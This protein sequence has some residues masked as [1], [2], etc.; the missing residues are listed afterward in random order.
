MAKKTLSVFLSLT[1]AALPLARP[2]AA[3]GNPAAQ[4]SS[5]P[6]DVIIAYYDDPDDFDVEDILELGGTL[7]YV[8][9]LV[10]AIAATVPESA[11]VE[12]TENFLVQRVDLDLQVHA[13]DAELDN[14][15]GVKRIGSGLVH[16][17]ANLGLGVKVAVLDSGID[18]IH[19][20]LNANFAGGHD[21]VNNDADPMD[22]EGHGTHV[23]GSIAAE[24][25]NAGLVGVA[26][27]AS[28]YVLKVL[29]QF[30]N[31][32]YSDI[33]AAL[34]WAVDN[35]M[36][37]TNNSY[38]SLGDPGLTVKQA[39]DNAEAAGLLNVAA[40]DNAGNC[41]GTGDSVNFPA[42]Y[43][44]VIAVAAT[45]STDG[46]PCFSSTGP[47]VEIAAPGVDINSTLLGGG[48]GL[49]SGTSMATPHVAGTGALVIA[50][51]ITDQNLNGRINDEVR[52]RM[53]Q[54]AEDLGLPAEWVGNGLVDADAA[55][56]SAPPPGE[57]A[58]LTVT[59]G[60]DQK[61]ETTLLQEGKVYV[62]QASDDDWWET[63]DAFFTS[64]QFSDAAVPAGATITS[65][66]IQVEHW[67]EK[68]FKGSVRW[69]AGTGW[70]ASPQVW[71]TNDSVPL[72]KGES[73]E[74]QDSGDVTAA[75]NTPA[76]INALELL[77]VNNGTNGKKTLVDYISV[78]VSWTTAPT[79]Q[80]PVADP[81]SATTAEDTPKAI[82]LTGS[83]LDGDPLT[84]TVLSQ[85]ANGTLS[86][87]APNLTYSPNADFNGS[88]SFTFKVNDGTV[89]S[90]PATVS[91][92][93]TAVN[94]APVAQDQQVSTKQGEPV[95]ITLAASDA[96]G[97]PLTYAVATAPTNGLLSGTPPNLTY[98]PNAGFSGTDSF[99]F[100]ANDGVLDSNLGTVTMTVAPNNP[101]TADP[102]SVTTAEDTPKAITLT[103]SDLDSDPLTFTV[104]SQPA[105]GTLSGTAPNLT[106]APKADFNGSDSFTF[107]VNDGLADS[108]PATVS[109]TVTAVNDA[110]TADD[111][112]V[113]TDQDTPVAVTLTAS[114]A[115]GDPLTFT[116]LTLP[117]NGTMSGPAPNLTYTPNAGF[118]G[119]DSF[120]FKTNDGTVDSAPGTVT[121]TVNE[122]SSIPPGSAVLTVLDGWD[123]KNEKTLEEDGKTYTVQTSDNEWWEIEEGYFTSYQFSDVAIPAG[124]KITKVE[125]RVE[126][127]EENDFQGSLE[128][129][130]GTGWP[131]SPQVWSTNPS[132]LLRKDE[133]NE[134]QD[135]WDVTG[136]VGTH[137]RI[138]GLELRIKNNAFNGKKTKAD[139][140]EVLVE[141]GP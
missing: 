78:Y 15:W 97:D 127:W 38:G 25:D 9:H 111:Q 101:P 1:L 123:Q 11:L 53:N 112:S 35:G 30:G 133:K 34:Q 135:S 132:I 90:A 44:S 40:A 31:G 137:A 110:P 73:N 22:D 49:G 7:K 106:Y 8:Y 32:N 118:F 82:T 45:N 89:D 98:T 39:F 64:Y 55:A 109:I 63:E 129:Q 54:T 117:A 57:S 105:N 43:A 102:Q 93:V 66:V 104:L 3:Q 85:P 136:A 87:T 81:Q 113:T 128:W 138:D 46:V 80:P 61:N 56:A 21:F 124:A 134:A 84:F 75:V 48:Y 100:K 14:S 71:A 92:T 72:R 6:V 86:G 74:T 62:L 130:A 91:I 51:G 122:K 139:Y 88:D 60:Y 59:D 69:Q 33:I 116:V 96:D 125:V 79:N 103:G 13:L 95:A 131:A 2:A 41:A 20:D 5:A 47:D 107:K 83:D 67:E 17:G 18:Y 37:V 114:D 108:L 42:R 94:D 141:W 29:D 19:P 16:D 76:R 24:D 26:P 119:T 126:H 99:T 28:L 50:S 36:Q 121:I 58:T 115:D 120:T 77:V 65:V 27:E 12:L 52:D 10:P 23:A 70:P 4:G 140:I 68:G